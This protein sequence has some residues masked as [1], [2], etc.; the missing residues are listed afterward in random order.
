LETSE[1][2]IPAARAPQEL[3]LLQRPQQLLAGAGIERPEALRLVRG[4]PQPWH[5]EEFTAYDIEQMI[6]LDAE[7]WC[8]L[9]WFSGDHDRS[10]GEQGNDEDRRSKLD[11]R[12]DA[13][14]WRPS[15]AARLVAKE[16]WG[17]IPCA[18]GKIS[19]SGQEC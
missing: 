4:Q 15:P 7:E 13:R 1:D 8:A 3:H 9:D 17:N 19:H 12:I 18:M 6:E 14:S 5:L 11:T 16:V 2:V 10:F